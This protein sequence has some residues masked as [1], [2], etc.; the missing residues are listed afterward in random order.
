MGSTKMH[1]HGLSLVH[2]IKHKGKKPGAV[3]I[4]FIYYY[5][6]IV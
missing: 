1:A 2:I 4:T 3:Y 5:H 6:A